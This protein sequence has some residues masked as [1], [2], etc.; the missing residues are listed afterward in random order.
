MIKP[1]RSALAL[2]LLISL[3]IQPSYAS[4]LLIWDKLSASSAKGY[5]L[6]LRH[7]LAPGVGDPE[8]FKLGDC[9]TQR[10]LSQEGRDD[11]SEIGAWIKRQKVKIYRVES[12]RWCRARQSAELL[13]IG[14]VK[15]NKNLDSLFRESNLESHPKTLKTKQQILNHRNKSGLLVLVGHYVNIA[16]LVGVGVDSGEGVIV[17]ANKNGVI[18]VLGATPNLASQN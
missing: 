18:K 8:N 16:A 14:K 11:A 2:I 5:V 6:L 15:L 10:N 17:K 3:S 9:S 12:S 4:E 1:L 7:S 13:D